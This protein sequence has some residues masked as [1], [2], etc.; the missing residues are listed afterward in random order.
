MKAALYSASSNRQALRSIN[1]AGRC[2]GTFSQR[3][4]RD[5]T[6]GVGV[7]GVENGGGVDADGDVSNE[8]VLEAVSEKLGRYECAVSVAVGSADDG[9]RLDEGQHW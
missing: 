5:D 7:A 2:F 4:S 3:N 8:T 9:V 1:S 6:N